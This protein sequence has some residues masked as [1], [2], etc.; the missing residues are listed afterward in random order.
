MISLRSHVVALLAAVLALAVGI[1]LGSGP[2]QTDMETRAAAAPAGDALRDAGAR[3]E[4]LQVGTE[5]SDEFALAVSDRL[6]R[7][8]LA[9]R[10]VTVLVLPGAGPET[11]A[12]LS[13]MVARAGGR[14]VSEVRVDRRLVD[15]ANRQLVGELGT[16]MVDSAGGAVRVGPKVGDYQRLGRLMARALVTSERAGAEPDAAG[17]GILAGLEAAGLVDVEQGDGTRGSL[18]LAVGGAAYGT[19]DER[20]GAGTIV[21]SL[22]AAAARTA[23]AVVLAAPAGSGRADGLVGLLVADPIARRAV[24]TVDGA[25]RVAGRIDTVLALAADASAAS[26]TFGSLRRG[27][28]IPAQ[29]LLA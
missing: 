18:L 24:S 5:Y 8:T 16:Q 17:T 28:G 23:R 20:E 26:R 15:V 9:G 13:E 19:Q 3:A 4:A 25:D 7:G 11:V 29:V 22:L 1:A 27:C 2:L 10:T 12:G 14:V 6:V 21:A